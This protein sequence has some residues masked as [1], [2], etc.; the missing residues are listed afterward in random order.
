MANQRAGRGQQK[1]G[2]PVA[3][4]WPIGHWP[5]SGPA[6]SLSCSPTKR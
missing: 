6:R 3:S 5:A 4:R 2:Y 1:G